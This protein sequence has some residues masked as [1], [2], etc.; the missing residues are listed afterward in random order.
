MI[1]KLTSPAGLAILLLL[2]FFGG[3]AG[4]L[5][6]SKW[7]LAVKL[8]QQSAVAQLPHVIRANVAA[9]NTF[10]VM[11][12]GDMFAQVP[13]KQELVVPLRGSYTA[14]VQLDAQIPISFTLKYQ[15]TI[16][17]HSFVDIEDNTHLVL[18]WLPKFPIKLHVPVDFDLPISLNIPVESVLPFHYSGPMP[19]ELNQDIKAPINTVLNTKLPINRYVTVPLLASFNMDVYPKN[20]VFLKIQQAQLALPLRNLQFSEH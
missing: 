19:I 9:T 15:D 17:V 14:D 11:L 2:A 13:F 8:E 4:F 12:Q 20:S 5:I 1:S 18:P 3:M 6:Y 16:K 7:F 10:D